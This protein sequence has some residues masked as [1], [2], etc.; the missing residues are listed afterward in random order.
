MAVPSQPLAVL[1]VDDEPLIRMDLA[2]T[3]EEA[4]FKVYEAANADQAVEL[5]EEVED[6][7]VLLTDVDM[8]GSM[9]GVQLAHYAR[10][11]WPVQIIVASGHREVG[12]SEL[13]PGAV[14]LGKPLRP[15]HVV[16]KLRSMLS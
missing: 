1:V 15:T 6:I 14:F 8:P 10:S 16:E 2:A 11:Y 9:D 3:I 4:G 12:L 7:K 5:L 13:P